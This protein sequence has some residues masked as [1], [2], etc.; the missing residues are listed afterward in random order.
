MVLEFIDL[1]EDE[2][3]I[4]INKLAQLYKV[5]QMIKNEINVLVDNRITVPEEIDKVYT[6]YAG[7][8]KQLKNDISNIVKLI[9]NK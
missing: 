5:K 6:K 3:K 9:N 8:I 1:T 7:Y 2:I 4:I